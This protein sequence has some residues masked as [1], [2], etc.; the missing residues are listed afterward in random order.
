MSLITVD[1]ITVSLIT[2]GLITVSLITVSLISK[3]SGG[4]AKRGAGTIEKRR[5]RIVTLGGGRCLPD[6]SREPSPKL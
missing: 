6:G 2:V 1:L 5:P 4:Q 3:V